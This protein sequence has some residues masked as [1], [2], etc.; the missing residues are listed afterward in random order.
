[1]KLVIIIKISWFLTELSNYSRIL[2]NYRIYTDIYFEKIFRPIR[3]YLS[4]YAYLKFTIPPYTDFIQ[5]FT[6]SVRWKSEQRCE[7]PAENLVHEIQWRQIS[8]HDYVGNWPSFC[9]KHTYLSLRW[10][11]HMV[12]QIF[13]QYLWRYLQ[14]KVAYSVNTWHENIMA[15]RLASMFTDVHLHYTT[16]ELLKSVDIQATVWN[17][18]L[19]GSLGGKASYSRPRTWPSGDSPNQRSR[20]KH[21]FSPLKHV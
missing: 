20:W 13:H 18:S 9:W 5:V 11:L 14:Q 1:M 6:F 8:P 10:P 15:T 2:N 4:L 19:W 12:N 7:I 21:A 16:F 3:P 17:I